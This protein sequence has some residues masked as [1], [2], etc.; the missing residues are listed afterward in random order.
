M[1]IVIVDPNPAVRE[2]LIVSI[3]D[4]TGEKCNAVEIPRFSEAQQVVEDHL[5]A[6]AV[7]VTLDAPTQ[8]GAQV[9]RD[10][11]MAHPNLRVYLTSSM[12]GHALASQLGLDGFLTKWDYAKREKLLHFLN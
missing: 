3:E 9:A 1:K 5:D 2:L 10:I 6:R 12:D 4:A 8:R 11:K 7:F